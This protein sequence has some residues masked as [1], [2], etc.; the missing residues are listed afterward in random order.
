[1][2]DFRGI[3]MI[4]TLFIEIFLLSLFFSWPSFAA[5]KVEAKSNEFKDVRDNQKYRIVNIA[6]RVWFADNL[7]YKM[8]GSFCY[9]DDEDEC[10]AYGRFYTWDIAV[11]AC[12]AGFRLPTEEDFESLWTEAGAD[13]NAAYLLKAAYGWSGETNG[14]DSLKFSAMPAGNRFDDETYGNEGKFAFFWS[15]KNVSPKDA[16]VWYMTSKS[17]GLNYMDKPKTFGFSVRCV[18]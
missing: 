2:D 1:M 18:K 16:Q 13:F 12:P 5:K 14:S 11:K 3:E 8:D 9:K 15:A 7:N 6:D 17:M 4:R 10:M